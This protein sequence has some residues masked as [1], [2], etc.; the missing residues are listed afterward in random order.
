MIKVFLIGAVLVIL[1][2]LAVMM[3]MAF[4]KVYTEGSKDKD[5]RD[6]RNGTVPQLRPSDHI[7]KDEE[8]EAHAVRSRRSEDQ[9]EP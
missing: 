6:V 9:A 2:P 4:V 7:Q 5:E 8:G 3:G 1:Y